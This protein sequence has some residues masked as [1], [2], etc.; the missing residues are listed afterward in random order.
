M[1]WDSAV[2]QCGISSPASPNQQL[3]IARLR[4]IKKNKGVLENMYFNFESGVTQIGILYEKQYT[5]IPIAKLSERTLTS[6]NKIPSGNSEKAIESMLADIR[7]PIHKRDQ[8]QIVFSS[9]P[10][11][12]SVVPTALRPYMQ[13]HASAPY[14]LITNNRVFFTCAFIPNEQLSTLDAVT[15]KHIMDETISS[16]LNNGWYIICSGRR[17]TKIDPTGAPNS[18]KNLAEHTVRRRSTH[19]QLRDWRNFPHHDHSDHSDLS[20]GSSSGSSSS[21]D[22]EPSPSSSSGSG[23]G[24]E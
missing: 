7:L 3:S 10:R 1:T 19:R 15:I 18:L 21:S 11:L 2:R 22:S 12:M 9:S 16:L 8:R 14:A 6:S 13:L 5:T 23:S 4:Q 20:S 24:S 17:I